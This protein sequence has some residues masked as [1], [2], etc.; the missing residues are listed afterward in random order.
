LELIERAAKT[1]PIIYAPNTSVGAYLTAIIS[2]QLAAVWPESDVA[3]VD[4][5][6][7]KKTDSP[8]GTALMLGEYITDS[9]SSLQESNDSKKINFA[10]VRVGEI[11]G[12]HEIIFTHMNEVIKIDYQCLSRENYAKGAIRA[13]KWLHTQSVGKLYSMVDVLSETI[14]QDAHIK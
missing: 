13:A 2:A 8:S 6:G 9:R 14:N 10:S 12:A 3:I 7:S 1:I 4:Y 5:H 11:T